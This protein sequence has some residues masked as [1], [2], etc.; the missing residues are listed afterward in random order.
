M[1]GYSQKY[2]LLAVGQRLAYLRETKEWTQDKLGAE[3]R[4]PRSTI[5]KW[6]NGAQDFKSETIVKLCRIFD[7]SA[8]YLLTGASAEAIDVHIKTGLIDSAIEALAQLKQNEEEC[9]GQDGQVEFMNELLSDE[10][11]YELIYQSVSLRN[12]WRKIDK[13]LIELKKL[14]AEEIRNKEEEERLDELVY[15]D[16]FTDGLDERLDY[17]SDFYIQT[18]ESIEALTETIDFLRWKHIQTLGKYVEKMLN[19]FGDG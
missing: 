18:T 3:L 7:V 4:V 17:F 9:F 8:D 5:A 15:K 1:S 16:P 14:Q 2:E 6:E 11:F 12:R 13:R 19:G 10:Q